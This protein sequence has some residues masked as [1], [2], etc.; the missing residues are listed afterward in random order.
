ML[1][2]DNGKCCVL[3]YT[4]CG[5]TNMCHY[6]RIEPYNIPIE[7]SLISTWHQS[8]N[9]IVVLRNPITR[10]LSAEMMM[11]DLEDMFIQ[12][13][14]PYMHLIKDYNFKIIDFE[15]LSLFIPRRIELVQSV[16]T[17]TKMNNSYTVDN[18]YVS[19]KGYSVN[20]LQEEYN[21]Y[22]E[23]MSSR[24]RLTVDEWKMLTV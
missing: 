10:V 24:Q 5:H 2:Y 16:Q 20:D 11:P 21:T 13:S 12:H 9:R 19:N 23:L 6:F 7:N 17:N 14:A 18:C 3:T 22:L 4:R 15:E 8:N 1:I